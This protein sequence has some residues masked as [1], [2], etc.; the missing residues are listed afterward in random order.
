MTLFA[1]LHVWIS[2]DEFTMVVLMLLNVAP[3]QLHLNGWSCIH[4]FMLICEVLYLSLSLKC[5]LYFYYTWSRDLAMWMSL[6]KMYPQYLVMFVFG[7]FWDFLSGGIW[8][9]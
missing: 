4:T 2:F 6:I 3:T 7:G 8:S 5:F 9:A 1:Q